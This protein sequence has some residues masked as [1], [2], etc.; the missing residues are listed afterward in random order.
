MKTL[1]AAFSTRITT[2][3]TALK[4]TRKDGGVLGVT[5]HDIDDP[6][7]GV[8]YL[9]NPGLDVS[10][11]VIAANAAV[12]NLELTTLHD[13]TVFTT[14]AIFDGLWRNTDFTIFRYNYEDLAG[15]VDTLLTGTLGENEIR[16]NEVF[17]ELHDLRQY[18]QQMVGSVS[19]KNCRYRLGS[20]DKNNGGLCTKD[21][22]AAPFTMPFVVTSVT[23]NQ[24][25]RDS[26]RAEAA[27]YFAEGEI[28]WL[29]GASVGVPAK[30]V[31]E[32]A[33]NGTFT[34]AIPMY[35]A[36]LVGDTGNVTVGCRKRF[37]EDCRIKFNNGLNFGG[38]KDRKGLNDLTKSVQPN[39]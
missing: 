28:E 9:S 12:G 25:F 33:A 1:P 20:T 7:S 35:S 31:K 27:D 21:V 29:T 14:A 23:S 6:I 38:E 39:V 30:K 16:L 3:A 32:Y 34:L 19:S 36:V 4:I 8:T 37:E 13:N 11:I 10:N 5:T 24:V 18:L 17:C 2:F 15:A 26:A 22:S